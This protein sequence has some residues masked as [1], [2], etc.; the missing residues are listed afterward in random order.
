MAH[1][2]MSQYMPSG[3]FDESGASERMRAAYERATEVVGENPAYSALACF[4]IG[5]G[6]GMVVTMLLKSAK[7]E[8][9]SWY[10][11]YMPDRKSVHDLANQVRETVSQYLKRR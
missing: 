3:Q 10:E 9:K 4:G 7:E 1:E 2:R 8:E 5:V 6:V 11:D